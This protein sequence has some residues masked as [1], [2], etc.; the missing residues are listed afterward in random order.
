[1]G[2][3]AV[4]DEKVERILPE[5]ERR[6]MARY[7]GVVGVREAFKANDR[8]RLHL[9]VHLR[10]DRSFP[11]SLTSRHIMEEDVGEMVTSIVWAV[12]RLEQGVI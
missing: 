8:Q 12:A 4:F 10:S 11:Y 9:L 3:R 5:V 1:M 2:Y 7:R 6:V